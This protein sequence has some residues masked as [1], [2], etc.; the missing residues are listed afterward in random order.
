MSGNESIEVDSELNQSVGLADDSDALSAREFDE[1]TRQALVE[2]LLFAHGEPLELSRIVQVTGLSTEDVRD[3]LESIRM[4]GELE[5]SGVELFECS[6]KFQLRTKQEF[7]QFL[8]K[9][10]EGRPKKLSAAALETL[11]II[12]YRQPIVKSDIEKIRGVDATPTLKTLLDRRV[13]RIV[14]HKSTIGQPALYGT[15]ELFL[16]IFGLQSL[17]ELPT[18]RDLKELDGD[19]GESEEEGFEDEDSLEASEAADRGDED[20]AD[21]AAAH[22]VSA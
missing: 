11:A 9:L 22:Q 16:S 14:G 21:S 3:I 8:S 12:A 7:G 5:E 13:I 18:L 10:R 2:A 20:E 17:A 15:T 4:Q 1:V 19:P 6:G